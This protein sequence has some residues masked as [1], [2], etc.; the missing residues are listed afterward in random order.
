MRNEHVNI[1]QVK[2]HQQIFNL[3]TILSN[4]NNEFL[5]LKSKIN[6]F[7]IIFKSTKKIIKEKIV[8]I[9]K[10]LLQRNNSYINDI[11]KQICQELEE[12]M[13]N[14]QNNHITKKIGIYK[15]ELLE[16]NDELIILLNNLQYNVLK[17]ERDLLIQSIQEK[18]EI[19]EIFKSFIKSEKDL[20]FLYIPKCI[21]FID[22]IYSVKIEN[23]QKD[24][25]YLK[26]INKNVIIKNNNQIKEIAEK[27]INELK[28]HL[29][30][31]KQKLNDFIYEKGF[32]YEFQNI[33][34][35]EKYNAEIDLIEQYNYSSESDSI[36]DS[37]EEYNQNNP[38]DKINFSNNE[39]INKNMCKCH[40]NLEFSKKNNKISMSISNKETNDQER[41]L[42]SN[43]Y[44]FYLLNKLLKLKEQY[45]KLIK[46]KIELEK[47]KEFK[48]KRTKEAKKILNKKSKDYCTF[49]S[50]SKRYNDEN[51][52]IIKY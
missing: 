32:K 52:N 42:S 45:N 29:Q 26:F 18:K 34:K 3:E 4:A 22:N 2:M 27:S 46:E 23:I 17:N 5:S 51:N 1:N 12:I 49:S 10:S 47:E 8:I 15:K 48:W 36:I 41:S 20:F 24:K 43:S 19:L 7:Q 39:N 14:Y 35:K 50:N 11:K 25:K 37:D 16:K 6:E 9:E 31:E 40:K 21:N 33:K 13:N 38:F 28:T 30:V 44:N